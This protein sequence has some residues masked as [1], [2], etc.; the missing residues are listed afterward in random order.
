MCFKVDPRIGKPSPIPNVQK[1]LN[2]KG[3]LPVSQYDEKE[4]NY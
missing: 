2:V 4:N 3:P 1:E